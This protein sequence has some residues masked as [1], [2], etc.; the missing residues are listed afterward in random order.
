MGRRFLTET[1]IEL[2]RLK[3]DPGPLGWDDDA[4]FPDATL[5]FTAD[6]LVQDTQTMQ[7][8]LDMIVTV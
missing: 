2:N 5:Q 3:N 4:G 6:L 7:A 1:Q 8:N